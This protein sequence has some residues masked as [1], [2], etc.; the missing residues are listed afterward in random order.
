MFSSGIPGLDDFH[1]DCG[2]H[3]SAAQFNESLIE[4]FNHVVYTID[5]S[6][7]KLAASIQSLYIVVIVVP[8]KV[9]DNV[10]KMTPVRQNI[11]LGYW[12]SAIK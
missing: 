7:E 11:W 4:I 5:Y 3:S 9:T 10:A 8:E 1:F 6:G 2:R 12:T